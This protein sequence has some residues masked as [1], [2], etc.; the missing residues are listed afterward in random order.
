ML[1]LKKARMEVDGQ[2][3]LLVKVEDSRGRFAPF[4]RMY[5]LDEVRA[6]GPWPWSLRR[7]MAREAIEE[8]RACFGDKW[9]EKYR[10]R[11][12]VIAVAVVLAIATCLVAAVIV[13]AR[14]HGANRNSIVNKTPRS[15]VMVNVDEWTRDQVVEWVRSARLMDKVETAK[16][17][18]RCEVLHEDAAICKAL[19]IGR[20]KPVGVDGEDRP[21]VA[22]ARSYI[23]S[24]ERNEVV[25]AI[26]RDAAAIEVPEATLLAALEEAT[27]P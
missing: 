17:F 12:R 1:R 4:S 27:S 3:V 8:G 15:A 9:V 13:S 11:D 22:A 25:A 2:P 14:A 20:R 24:F 18:Q 16:V 6:F 19:M 21:E 26:A 7:H 10:T 5:A 23:K